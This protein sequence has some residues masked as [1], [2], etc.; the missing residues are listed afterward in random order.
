M[1]D[2]QQR[3]FLVSTLLYVFIL[4]AC[5]GS[6]P[7]PTQS[8]AEIPTKTILPSSKST[9]TSTPSLTPT[10]TYTPP[11]TETP[12]PTS[13]QTTTPTATNVS[14]NASNIHYLAED[15]SINP[16]IF[17]GQIRDAYWS[18]DDQYIILISSRGIHL[19]N[20][21]TM[22]EEAFFKDLI[23]RGEIQS[24]LLLTYSSESFGWIN[25]STLH[26][27]SINLTSPE[28]EG[29]VIPVSINHGGDMLAAI[30]ENE[31]DNLVVYSFPEISLIE[32]IKIIHKNGIKA[33]LN[34]LFSPDDTAIFLHIKR[35]DQRDGLLR[36]DLENPT[37]ITD[38][39]V[40]LWLSNLE[41]S[42]EGNRLAYFADQAVI[43][44]AATGNLWSTLSTSFPSKVENQR[45]YFNGRTMSFRDNY[46]LGIAYTYRS[47]N[48][49]S[50]V[51][52]WDIDTGQVL[53]TFDHLPGE[54][55]AFDF[56]HDGLSFLVAT[57]DG[58]IRLYDQHGNESIKSEPYDTG[59]TP[60]FSP[61]G[62][63]IA[64][65]SAQGI[66]IFDIEKD[67]FTSLFGDFPAGRLTSVKF[68]D[69]S[70]LSVS[71]FSNLGTSFT[72]IWNIQTEEMIRS[73]VGFDCIFSFNK[74]R[75]A[76]E[77]KYVQVLD[78]E[79]GLILGSFGTANQTFDFQLSPDG[80]Q[81]AICSYK[82][83][84]GEEAIFSEA[85]G[86]WDIKSGTRIRNLLKDGPACGKLAFSL[87]G[88]YLISSAGAIWSLPE[89]D[90]IGIF[91]GQPYGTITLSQSNDF[92]LFENRLIEFPSGQVLGEIR[93]S[94]DPSLIRFSDD[95]DY[96]IVL[97]NQTI[98]YWRVIKLR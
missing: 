43:R 22:E 12:L 48:P 61:N 20:S 52:V 67:K 64:I 15:F 83:S 23:P 27:E 54:V 4:A 10:T 97:A 55:T 74:T 70:T 90:L 87:S 85:V 95:G 50:T 71:G 44:T 76:C 40:E 98:T 56:S 35:S 30:D 84:W 16:S 81:L 73:F 42:P 79:L 63:L 89:G 91:E 59:G 37:M 96:L 45:V 46:S 13:T 69:Q 60:D 25:L 51:L 28:F 2:V 34:I 31:P 57:D 29:R 94:E 39:S 6:L 66:Q 8:I 32:K 26:F 36:V 77:D 58:L 19:L 72:E 49:Q 88:D 86:L 68:L 41:I 62:K 47:N 3:K 5:Q 24:N 65:P 1:S 14:M 38:L 93:F 75:L 7:E 9:L 21:E 17:R 82:Y 33:I 80:Q 78:V 18:H 53:K 92:F 11:P